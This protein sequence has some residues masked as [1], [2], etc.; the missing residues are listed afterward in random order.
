MNIKSLISLL[1]SADR[2]TW[3]FM[4]IAGLG[5]IS[6]AVG[7]Y[8]TYE[9]HFRHPQY[10]YLPVDAAWKQH[11][12]QV[13]AIAQAAEKTPQEAVSSVTVDIS[14]AVDKP[15]VYQISTPARY[16]DAVLMAGGFREEADKRYIHQELN[17]AAHVHDQQKIYIP[18]TGE[19]VMTPGETPSVGESIATTYTV[20]TAPQKVLESI[21]GIGPKRAES[22]LAGRPYT[23]KDDFFER[24]GLSQALAETVLQEL[25]SFE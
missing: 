6:L 8:F 12:D 21:T 7:S 17:L 20:N 2:N 24:A 19:S 9:T 14:G 22:I 10:S 11:L 4:A 5:L 15:G 18:F 16:Q 3:S 1:R 13:V 23:S 25:P